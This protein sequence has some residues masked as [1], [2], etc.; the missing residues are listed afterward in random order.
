MDAMNWGHGGGDDEENNYSE[1]HVGYGGYA[2]NRP[3]V[4]PEEMN[5]RILSSRKSSYEGK[6]KKAREQTNDEKRIE[7]YL[8]ALEY[9]RQYFEESRNR[10]ISI[11]GMPD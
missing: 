11:E 4:S 2:S 3:R 9:G 1:S 5:R 7:Y 8:E 10:G 6:L